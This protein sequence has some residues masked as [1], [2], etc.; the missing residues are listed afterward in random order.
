MTDFYLAFTS[1][2]QANGVLFTEHYYGGE[3]FPPT[4]EGYTVDVLGFT[5]KYPTQYLVNLTGA[6]T[7]IWN[8]YQ[9]DPPPQVPI[10]VF[11]K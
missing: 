3:V 4:A 5:E 11:L 1:E 7:D 2:E 9:P 10:R 6:D 8:A